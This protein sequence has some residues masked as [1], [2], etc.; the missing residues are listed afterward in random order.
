[1]TKED[2]QPSK[3]W[4]YIA[5]LVGG[6]LLLAGLATTVSFL[7]LP[8]F[9][10]GD[11]VLGYQLGVIAGMFLGIIVGSLA[12]IHGLS[13]ILKRRSRPFK[14]VPGYV[15]LLIFVA[16]LGLGNLVLNFDIAS[17]FLFPPLFV[18]GAALPTVTVIAW[19]VRR[20]GWPVTWRQAALAFV[21][22]STLSV[23]V[24]ILLESFLPFVLYR[25]FAPLEEAAY[26]LSYELTSGSSGL[27]ER[28]L[29]S[30]LLLAFL[31]ITALE[32]P[33][34]EEFAK[35]LG[36]T[37]FGRKRILDERQAFIIGMVSGAG[38]AILENM[39]YEGLYA[40]SGGWSWGGITLL[41]GFG[42][43]LHP[44]TTGLVT[45][46]WFRARKS[47]W[48][49]LLKAY[50]VAVGLHT[51]WNGGFLPFVYLT[52]L[53]YYAISEGSLSIYG[54]GI[55]ILLVAFLVILS[56]G[57]WWLLRRVTAGMAQ[58]VAP[59]LTPKSIS[60][61]A[62]AIWGSACLMV[63]VPIGAALNP[64]WDQIK[65]VILGVP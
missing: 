59:D 33:L 20:L 12:L 55:E 52:G 23:I 24:A 13:S 39:L 22:G 6:M 15:F 41:R 34:P 47:G 8:F 45:L 46:G 37:F 62:L 28:L 44:L 53:D 10:A 40:Q 17:E 60:P 31:I 1:M 9:S 58:D 50:L 25:L 21:A 3:F 61:R 35:A 64:A 54:Q 56:I 38:F 32:A 30:P 51:L 2:R 49:A 43:V 63:I 19:T 26:F 11:D 29:T 4:A 27:L 16:A 36:I 57:L 42:S 7:G 65:D 14:L 18:L 48:G 5:V